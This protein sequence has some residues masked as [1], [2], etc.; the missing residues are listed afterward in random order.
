MRA[1]AGGTG[2]RG[3]EDPGAPRYAIAPIRRV[4][5]YFLPLAASLAV[6]SL[7]T[8]LV[9]SALARSPDPQVTL[10]SFAVALSLVE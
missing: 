5:F 10:A 8:P 9:N 2:C 7:E 6:N 3:R 4:W 1:E